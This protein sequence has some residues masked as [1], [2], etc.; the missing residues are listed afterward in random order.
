MAT[1][2]TY[3]ESYLDAFER[4]EKESAGKGPAWLAPLR[5]AAISRFSEIGIPTRRDEEWKYTS[6]T[7]IAEQTFVSAP[8]EQSLGSADVARFPFGDLGF[9]RLVFV[10]GGYAPELSSLKALPNGV[11]VRSLAEAL[12]KDSS[13]LESR[14]GR[15]ISFENRAFVALNTAFFEDGALVYVPRNVIVEDPIQLLFISTVSGEPTVSYPRNLIVA[16]ENSQ[17]T[18]IETYVGAESGVTLTNA[19]TEFV[20]GANAVVD[21]SKAQSEN[22]ESYHI[23]ASQVQLEGG[24]NFTSQSFTFGGEIV[25]ND[26]DAVFNGEYAECTLNGLYLARGTQMVDNH[27]MIDHA[28]AHCNSHELYKGV[29]DDDSRGVFNGKIFVRPDAQKTD[30]KQTNQTLLLSRQ[31][32]INTKPQLEIFAD[33]VRCTHGATVGQ[34]DAESVFY[35]RS[36]GIAEQDARNILTHA[37]AGDIIDRVKVEAL[38]E[39]LET[40]LYVQLP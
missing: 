1:T 35:L 9:S 22:L 7:Q 10:N 2:L 18:L 5:K 39:A 11:E 37:F 13:L 14:L 8:R 38:K 36:R 32:Q 27:T 26:V 19:V 4:F 24:S 29:L 17:V 15:S 21:H 23:S 25:R 28:S 6:V 33:D 30:A 16:E 31:A 20:V 12:A 40:A 3:K 34:L